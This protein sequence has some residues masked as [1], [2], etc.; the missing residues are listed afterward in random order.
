MILS[1]FTN[2]LTHETH[3]ATLRLA[4]RAQGINLLARSHTLANDALS[5]T[6][7]LSNCRFHKRAP[8]E[9]KAIA[10]S[11]VYAERAHALALT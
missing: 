1:L 3:V 5:H 4:L 11:Y 9:I 6:E 2:L 10:L 8:L 7:A